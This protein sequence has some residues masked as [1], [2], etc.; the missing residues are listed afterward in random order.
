MSQIQDI[1]RKCYRDT[2]G[3]DYTGDLSKYDSR[4]MLSTINMLPQI[5]EELGSGV[6]STIPASVLPSD[7]EVVVIP[8]CI[9]E[10]REQGYIFEA[11]A[12]LKRG[13]EPNMKHDYHKLDNG[14]WE[15][16]LYR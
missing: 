5:M 15:L 6:L 9:S 16:R 4:S 11:L 3:Y 2:Y 13:V 7:L 10:N 8:H 1:I 14:K 12:G